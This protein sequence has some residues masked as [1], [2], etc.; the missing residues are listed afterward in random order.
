MIMMLTE[1]FYDNS[2]VEIRRERPRLRGMSTPVKIRRFSPIS[3]R[4]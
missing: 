1:R 4:T 2:E 3:V